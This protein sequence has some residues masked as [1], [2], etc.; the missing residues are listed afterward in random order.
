MTDRPAPAAPVT[1]VVRGGTSE[2]RRTQIHAGTS[3]IAVDA[4]W[5]SVVPSESPGP[6]ELLASAFAACLLK[7]VERS[8][9]LMPFRYRT[10][11]VEVVATRQDSPPLFREIRYELRL[12]T[13]EPERRV[14]LL[15]ENLRRHGTVYN[16][17]AAVCEVRGSI[18]SSPPGEA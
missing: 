15:H 3:V 7:N 8:A 13:D 17:L 4:S 5:P 9:R 2:D 18:T 12:V 10:A 11:E 6:G 14:E 1:Y 16:T